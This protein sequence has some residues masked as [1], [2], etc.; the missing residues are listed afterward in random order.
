M[1]NNYLGLLIECPFENEL[2]NC[3]FSLIRRLSLK[4]A[5]LN[6]QRMSYTEQKNW[7]LMH[8]ECMKSRNVQLKYANQMQLIHIF[9]AIM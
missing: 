9:Y 5:L 6:W 2:D 8:C 7:I 3:T 1:I 4:L